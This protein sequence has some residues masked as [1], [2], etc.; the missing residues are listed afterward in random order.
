MSLNTPVPVF[1]V[2]RS[3]SHGIAPAVGEFSCQTF[4]PLT[5]LASTVEVQFGPAPW[6]PTCVLL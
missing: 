1:D 2:A 6:V 4:A 5:T 3:R